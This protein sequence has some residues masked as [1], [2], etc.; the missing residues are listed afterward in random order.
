MR[1]EIESPPRRPDS[2]LIR[3]PL[4]PGWKLTGAHLDG[5]D[6]APELTWRGD[7]AINLPWREGHLTLRTSVARTT[8]RDEPE[9]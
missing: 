4:P 5:A 7:G 2:W 3:L 8:I 9:R 1:I 6:P